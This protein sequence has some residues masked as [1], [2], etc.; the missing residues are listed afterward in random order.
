MSSVKFT[1]SNLLCWFDDR[2]FGQGHFL[3]ASLTWL[4]FGNYCRSVAVCDLQFAQLL[5]TDVAEVGLPVFVKLDGVHAFLDFGIHPINRLGC[6]L[7]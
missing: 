7:V 1:R 2:D 5:V 4:H 3:G 6:F